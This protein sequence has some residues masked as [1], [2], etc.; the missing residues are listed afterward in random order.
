M[1]NRDLGRSRLTA[2]IV[3]SVGLVWVGCDGP[4]GP[5]KPQS[6]GLTVCEASNV[7]RRSNF[8]NPTRIDNKWSPLVPGT[9]FILD[10]EADRGGGLLPHRV[11]FTVT[12]L[13]KEI[14]GVRC[15]VMWDRDYNNLVLG[16]AEL[17]FFAQDDDG[18]VWLMGEYPE[19]Y[20]GDIFIGAPSTWIAGLAGA[21]AGIL[22]PGSSRLDFQFLQGWAPDVNFLDC[23]RTL[24][25]GQTICVPY[26]C[27]EDVLV[28][29]EWSPIESGSAHQRKYYAPYVGNVFVGA[30]DDPEGETLVLTNV[31]HL[32]PQLLAEARAAAL[33]LEARAYEINELY[34][35]TPPAQ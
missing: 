20:E 28:V 19:E 9:Q 16:E 2:V 14:N 23:G 26:N 33:K 13:T 21:D 25:T 32:G 29:D 22:V 15:V 11:V 18:N 35:R 8:T 12:D 10:G 30:V 27:F 3:A 17:A 4:S 6:P 24:M 34:R 5:G 31:L 7:F 1:R